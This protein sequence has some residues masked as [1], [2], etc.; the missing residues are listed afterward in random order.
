MKERLHD[1]RPYR[2]IKK[3]LQNKNKKLFIYF[4][5]L[6]QLE[7]VV[8]VVGGGYVMRLVMNIV[9]FVSAPT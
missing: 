7:G 6:S 4:L 8:V 5:Q 9:I 2:A 3:Q 1:L